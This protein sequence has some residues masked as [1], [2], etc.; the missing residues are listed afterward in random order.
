MI[1]T[2]PSLLQS[3]HSIATPEEMA[4]EYPNFRHQITG[5][6][7][8]GDGFHENYYKNHIGRELFRSLYIFGSGDHIPDSYDG[9]FRPLTLTGIQA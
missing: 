7:Y 3:I 8:S 4:V 1:K 6:L 9:G 5:Y 2:G